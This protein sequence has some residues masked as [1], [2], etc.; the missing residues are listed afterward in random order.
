M[1][2]E[3]IIAALRAHEREL[4]QEGI[5]SLSLIGSVARDE[6]RP[7]SDIDVLVRLTDEV[8][9]GGFAYF[10]RIERLRRRL[11]A[12]LTRHV[13]VIAEPVQKERLR[14]EVERDRVLA[15]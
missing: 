6:D 2:R 15:F 5:A 11:E 10:G 14:R 13:D 12:I 1:K 8:R 4:K 3:D 7:D 9:R